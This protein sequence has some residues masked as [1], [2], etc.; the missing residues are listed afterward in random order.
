MTETR[1]PI[2]VDLMTYP[3]PL[4]RAQ[5]LARAA[6]SAGFDGIAMTEVART[7]YLSL[8]AMALSAS[9]DYSTAVAVAFA[10]SPMVTAQQAWELA[11]T[12]VGRFRLGLGTQVRSHI[13]RRYSATFEHPG[14][15]MR[16][17][18]RSLRAIFNA[19]QGAA[20]LDYEGDYFKFSLLP[21]EWSP[22]PIDVDPPPIDVAG[23]NPWMIRMAGEVADGLHVHPL[24]TTDYLDA[25]VRVE[26]EAGAKLSKRDPDDLTVIVPCFAIAGETDVE[27]DKWRERARQRVAFYGSTPNYTFLFDRI[28]FEGTTTALQKCFRAGDQAGARRVISD[29]IL[30]H[31]T[32]EGTWSTI[33]GAIVERYARRAQRVILY[34]V[35]GDWPNDPSDLAKWG[36]VAADIRR[37][38]M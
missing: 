13:E 36:A 30:A 8:A 19:F 17:Y 31:F 1:S 16:D 26:L 7:P 12:T 4:R 18:V 34:D 22:G 28:G 21:K 15:R 20:A 32:V 9:L 25:I 37:L 2:R 33:A 35:L 14:P 29:D 27:R 6:Q 38:T 10:S 11:E 23:V 24:N 5:E 3:L